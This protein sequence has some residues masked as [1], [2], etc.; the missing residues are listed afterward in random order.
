[1]SHG[2]AG[3]IG[4][5]SENRLLPVYYIGNVMPFAVDF[6]AWK[7]RRTMDG[8]HIVFLRFSFAACGR[9]GR[10]APACVRPA[11]YVFALLFVPGFVI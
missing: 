2:V 9:G 11:A 6:P 1:M 7:A 3:N 4:V 10:P 8:M 5:P